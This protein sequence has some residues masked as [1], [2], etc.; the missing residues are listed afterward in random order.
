MSGSVCHSSLEEREVFAKERSMAE[1]CPLDR[2]ILVGCL[3]FNIEIES[4]SSNSSII[5]PPKSDLY[6][7][8]V[9]LWLLKSPTMTYG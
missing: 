6:K 8:Q 9:S 1:G 3:L 7:P 4:F 5:F 2:F